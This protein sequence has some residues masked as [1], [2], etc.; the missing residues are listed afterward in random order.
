MKRIVPVLLCGFA[1]YA[2]VAKDANE[3]YQTPEGRAAVA[4]GLGASNRDERQK[5]VELVRA[6]DLRAGMA[7]ADIGTGVGYML[8]FLSQAV[9]ARGC[10][11][12]EDI[13]DDFLNQA[14]AH[15]AEE[16][17]TNVQFV[18][19]TVPPI[20]PFTCKSKK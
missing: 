3:R 9:G 11:F 5:P 19:G 7:V 17:L 1:L 13:F 16:K 6:M 2:Q 4:K 10:V 14:K 20:Q 18:K 12:A 8:P 15:A